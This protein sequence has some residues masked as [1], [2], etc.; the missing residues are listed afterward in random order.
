MLGPV[1]V[2]RGDEELILG[3]PQQRVVLAALLLRRR[4]VVTT[5][6]IVHAVWGE[7]PP[8][9]ALPVL[10]TYVSRL[11]KILEPDRISDGSRAV[12]VSATDGYLARV[13]EDAVD[14]GV[15]EQR[16]ADAKKLRVAGE[17]ATASQLLHDAL[18][19]WHET[20][21]AGLTGPLVDA[22]RS[23]LNEARLTTLETRFDIDV[24]LGR[25]DTVISE[26][27]A[28]THQHPL[29][30]RLCQLLMIALYRSGRQ[31]EALACYRKT[32]ST[33][34]AELGIEP[35]TSLRELHHKILTADPSLDYAPRPRRTAAPSASPAPTAATAPPS[36]TPAAAPAPPAASVNRPAQLPADLATFSGRRTELADVRDLLPKD[37]DD[38]Q[39]MTISVVSG[40]AGI[41]K[42]TL[43]VHLA[44][45]VADRFP[46]GQLFI[47]LRGFDATG[48]VMAPEEAIRI[49]LDALGV[50]R[51]A[52]PRSRRPRRC[53][54]APCSPAAAC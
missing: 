51:S 54:T 37:S 50:P 16:V 34:V 26:L 19:G 36:T 21:L 53:C 32:R 29:R 31:A 43:A 11:R 17:L 22:E 40:M 25:H 48:S 52:S 47:N 18:D 28:L 27:R 15:F 33:L 42:T 7:D 14:L 12:L 49:F 30:E 9:A 13:P 3:S 5:T 8:T 23:R 39:K 35:G 2:W 38:S 44:H 4:R 1:R 20:P 41:G 45:E 6:E 46:D 10:R 24:Q